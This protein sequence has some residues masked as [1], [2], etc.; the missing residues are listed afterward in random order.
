MDSGMKL[1]VKPQALAAIREARGY[2]EQDLA[3]AL[4]ISVNKIKAF[5][6]GDDL[7]NKGFVTRLADLFYVPQ[8]MFFSNNV[9]LKR[10]IADFRTVRNLPARVGKGG[11]RQISQCSELQDVLLEIIPL[12]DLAYFSTNIR[13]RLNDDVEHAAELVANFLDLDS[14]GFFSRQEPNELF[15]IAR[16]AI[17]R[18]KIGVITHRLAHETFRGFCLAER[19]Q[20]PLIFINTYDQTAKTKLF[21]LI[22]ELVHVFIRRDGI[23]DPF[24]SD[25]EIERF[26]NGITARVL[27]PESIFREAYKEFSSIRD[28]VALTRRLSD[29]LGLSLHAI[30][31]RINELNLRAGFYSDWIRLIASRYANSSLR[32]IE[33]GRSDEI[34]DEDQDELILRPSSARRLISRFG[35]RVPALLK[36]AVDKNILSINDGERLLG[37]S[38]VHL[39]RAAEIVDTEFGKDL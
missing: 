15:S 23:S 29:R 31:L 20:T 6:A 22:H 10:N 2:S 28:A 25:T 11:I 38:S 35:Y 36:R 8:S 17:E 34:E 12:L 39:P 24:G 37:L 3:S 1:A 5:E 7:P 9:A 16:R 33:E 4:A 14:A 19:N 21:T 13:L 27:M 32:Q 26:C 30:A 18:K